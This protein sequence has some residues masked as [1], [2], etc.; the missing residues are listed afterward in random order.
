MATDKLNTK[1]DQWWDVIANLK[2]DSPQ[3]DWD[4]FASYT[5]P[6][7]VLYF[8]GLSQPPA[9]GTAEAVA[10]L[11]GLLAYWAILERRVLARGVDADGKTAFVNMNN[12]LTIMG[13]ELDFA[14]AEVVT[15][16]EED[17]IVD[18]KLYFDPSPVMAIFQ[19]KTAAGSA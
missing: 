11:K 19:K 17:R 8:N 3:E 15:F 7:S 16:D 1:L 18:Y 2:I 5:S 10:A 4:K 9:R 13:E 14:E 12:R 6:E